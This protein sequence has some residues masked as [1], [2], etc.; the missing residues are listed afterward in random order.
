MNWNIYNQINKNRHIHYRSLWVS[1]ITSK[2]AGSICVPPRSGKTIKMCLEI[3]LWWHFHASCAWVPGAENAPFSRLLLY[4]H[5]IVPR[6]ILKE[7]TFSMLP[8]AYLNLPDSRRPWLHGLR[9]PTS[10]ASCL[11][12]YISIY[13]ISGISPILAYVDTSIALSNEILMHH[14]H[15]WLLNTKLNAFHKQKGIFLKLIPLLHD[16][17]N[18]ILHG[19]YFCT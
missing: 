11:W 9:N 17:G 8:F 19:N 7:G 5:D 3:E 16:K 10:R 12:L 2:H 15:Q 4:H 18:S 6:G 13:K 1:G 14:Y